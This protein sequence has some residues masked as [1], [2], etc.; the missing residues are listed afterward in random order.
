MHNPWLS[1]KPWIKDD[2]TL[3]PNLQKISTIHHFAPAIEK[4][5][6]CFGDADS[7][8]LCVIYVLLFPIVQLSSR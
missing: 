5:Q 3:L 4:D 8:N 6:I 2:A 1:V 7:T